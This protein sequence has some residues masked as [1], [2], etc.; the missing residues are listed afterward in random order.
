MVAIQK[1]E[2][3]KK[4]VDNIDEAIMAKLESV[5]ISAW[6]YQNLICSTTLG[7]YRFVID[8]HKFLGISHGERYYIS[9]YLHNEPITPL[10]EATITHMDPL[11]D[12][13]RD[14]YGEIMNNKPDREKQ[15]QEQF[16]SWL[17]K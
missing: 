13:V 4:I 12:R 8:T 3:R 15:L 6:L 5:T 9:V 16:F 1:L 7:A 11:Y 2:K 17:S 14:L 10:Y